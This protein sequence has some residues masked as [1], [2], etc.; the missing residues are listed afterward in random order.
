MK[1][2]VHEKA[3]GKYEL[4]LMITIQVTQTVMDVLLS[5]SPDAFGALRSRLQAAANSAIASVRPRETEFVDLAGQ[6]LASHLT[7]E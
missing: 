2:P 7:I 1:I 6:P 3:G 4:R 5:A